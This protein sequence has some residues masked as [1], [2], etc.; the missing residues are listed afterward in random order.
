MKRKEEESYRC[1]TCRQDM[2]ERPHKG[3]NGESCVQCG[4]SLSWRK[5]RKSKV[6]K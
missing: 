5:V 1:P 3:L 2:R 4:Q 6:S